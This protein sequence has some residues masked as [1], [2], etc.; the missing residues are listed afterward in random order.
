MAMAEA[1][2]DAQKRIKLDAIKTALGYGIAPPKA[3]DKAPGAK[4]DL[5]EYSVAELE[6][7]LQDAKANAAEKA[8]PVLDH[9]PSNVPER[10]QVLDLF[11]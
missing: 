9:A 1:K 7:L 5:S 11:E 4:Q 2:T 10:G 8:R 3:S 6:Q